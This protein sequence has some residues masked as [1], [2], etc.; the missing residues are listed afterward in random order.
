MNLNQLKAARPDKKSEKIGNE[1]IRAVQNIQNLTEMRVL[2]LCMLN[3]VID[4]DGAIAHKFSVSDFCDTF[5]LKIEPG[6]YADIRRSIDHLQT[7]KIK[8]NEF[9]PS[10]IPNA[11]GFY[12]EKSL[13]WAPTAIYEKGK[14]E[15]EITF[16]KDL[17][18]MLREVKAFFTR[19]FIN[20]IVNFKS[21]QS[22]RLFQMICSYGDTGI[23]AI[24]LDDLHEILNSPVTYRTN[25]GAFKR[26]V[27]DPAIKEITKVGGITGLMVNTSC[28]T[29]KKVT[30]LTF[31]FDIFEK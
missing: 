10:R 28:G 11:S 26:R 30:A 7:R 31:T 25:S 5:K 18:V 27:I 24:K 29:G 3:G 13:V 4:V 1:L 23:F 8:F 12:K 22:F 14:G 20:D 17:T 2:Y 21:V 6:I 16:H 9:W 15:I 19:V